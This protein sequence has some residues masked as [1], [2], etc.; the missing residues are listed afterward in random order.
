MTQMQQFDGTEHITMYNEPERT[1]IAAILGLVCSC[2]GCCF[3]VTAI[4]GVFLSIFGVV[5]ISRSKGRIGGMGFAIAGL[6]IGLL[7]LA[8]WGGAVGAAVY[9]AKQIDAA[10][11]QPVFGV[12]GDLESGDFDSARGALGSPAA[13]ATDEELVVF[14]AGYQAMFGSAVSTPGGLLEY[15][16]EAM[17]LGEP[18]GQF[19]GASN[20]IPIPME[21]ERGKGLVVIFF[22]QNQANS[23]API[24]AEIVIFDQDGNSVSLPAGI[25]E[26][27]SDAPVDPDLP[28]VDV[29]DFTNDPD[30]DPADEPVEDS[31]DGP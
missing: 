16:G 24:A 11:V 8:L 2:I 13:D 19:G 26:S 27:V 31:A 9:G 29:E 12:L 23:G 7:M 28:G 1:S 18:L 6:L 10:V 17:E 30:A 21:F 5:G 25:A 4:L 14:L 3:G 20:L 15:I 22:D